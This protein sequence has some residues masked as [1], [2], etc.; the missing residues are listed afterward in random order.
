MIYLEVFLDPHGEYSHV[1][2]S[3]EEMIEELKRYRLTDDSVQELIT[4]KK[5]TI[6]TYVRDTFQYTER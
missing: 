3:K 2:S 5:I 4:S 6:G 1:F